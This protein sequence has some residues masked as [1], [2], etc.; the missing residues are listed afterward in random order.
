MDSMYMYRLCVS[1]H[2]FRR[3]QVDAPPT[4]SGATPYCTPRYSL[5]QDRQVAGVRA[6]GV[7][8]VEAKVRG[9]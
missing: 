4:P 8:R 2:L 5:V 9:D 6:D 3:K 1:C 7:I